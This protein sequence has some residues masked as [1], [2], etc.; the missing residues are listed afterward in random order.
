MPIHFIEMTS[1]GALNDP[2]T[3]KD[4][5]AFDS[6]VDTPGSQRYHMYSQNDHSPLDSIQ[7]KLQANVDHSTLIQ[8]AP[9]C[10]DEFDNYDSANHQNSTIRGLSSLQMEHDTA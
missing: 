7:S 3:W 6:S 8:Y 1:K 2:F 5:T 4:G 9:N 10:A